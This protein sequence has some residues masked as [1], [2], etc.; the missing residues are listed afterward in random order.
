M[1]C[2]LRILERISFSFATF[3]VTLSFFL[4]VLAF[5]SFSW[6]CALAR[7]VVAR[8]AG[9]YDALAQFFNAYFLI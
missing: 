4:L 9:S 1:F 7:S 3:S 5:L 2:T 8:W 6:F